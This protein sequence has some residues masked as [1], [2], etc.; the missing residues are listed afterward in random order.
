MEYLISLCTNPND[1]VFDPFMGTGTT[2]VACKSMGR[3]FIGCELIEEYFLMA[4]DRLFSQ[5]KPVHQ[6]SLF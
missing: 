6:M 1:I 4:R 5:D 2:G 3:K